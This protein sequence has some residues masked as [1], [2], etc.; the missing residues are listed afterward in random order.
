[1][2]CADARLIMRQRWLNGR[3]AVG[4]PV[5]TITYSARFRELAVV[6][7]LIG[8]DKDLALRSVQKLRR[9]HDIG[10]CGSGCSYG[11]DGAAGDS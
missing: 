7:F 10:D 3:R 11:V 5:D 1:M 4:P 6:F 2:R 9:G 8:F